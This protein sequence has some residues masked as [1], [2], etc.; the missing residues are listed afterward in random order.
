MLELFRDTLQGFEY[1]WFRGGKTK[2]QIWTNPDL[3]IVY[4]Y[5]PNLNDKKYKN[6]VKY[7]VNIGVCGKCFPHSNFTG[8]VIYGGAHSKVLS[9]GRLVFVDDMVICNTC[10]EVVVNLGDTNII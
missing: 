6:I 5:Y 10:G 9:E 4:L 7:P 8:D 1:L 3:E 2:W